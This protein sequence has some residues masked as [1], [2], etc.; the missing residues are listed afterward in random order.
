MQLP[1]HLRRETHDMYAPGSKPGFAHSE[2][3]DALMSVAGSGGYIDPLKLGKWLGQNRNAIAH[4]VFFE[5]EENK[6]G[7]MVW[8]LS[9]VPFT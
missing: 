3:R 6:N 5:S 8:R 1:G 9:P 7:T 2:F 4:S